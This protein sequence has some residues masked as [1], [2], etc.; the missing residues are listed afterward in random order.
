MIEIKI[1]IIFKINL[2]LKN[3]EFEIKKSRSDFGVSFI[4]KFKLTNVNETCEIYRKIN[5]IIHDYKIIINLKL[6]EKIK[7]FLLKNIFFIS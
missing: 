2:D 4:I 5:H 1:I 3:F 6:F 7:F